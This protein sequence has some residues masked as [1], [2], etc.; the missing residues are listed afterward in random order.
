LKR[1][2][3]GRRGPT[4]ARFFYSPTGGRHRI[5]RDREGG[6]SRP[7]ASALQLEV[8]A[9]IAPRCD[10]AVWHSLRKCERWRA[11]ST[12]RFRRTYQTPTTASTTASLSVADRPLV[13]DV[14]RLVRHQHG[15][16]D[17]RDVAAT[18]A[19]G[20]VVATDV[21]ARGVL[22]ERGAKRVLGAQHA[23]RF[24]HKYRPAV[25]KDT[26]MKPPNGGLTHSPL[27]RIIKRPRS[28]QPAQPLR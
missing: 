22:G 21:G 11:R 27:G 17:R 16:C 20:S 5:A 2:G 13:A 26:T 28:Q 25:S 3:E 19:A 14:A 24:Q 18:T 1:A 23:A 12:V 6:V 8:T 10:R 9:T 15:L 4:L 7:L